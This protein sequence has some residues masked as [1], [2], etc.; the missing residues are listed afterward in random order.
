MS[1]E[2]LLALLVGFKYL[3]LYILVIVEGFFT[4]VAGGALAA[5]GIMN[6]FAVMAIVVLGD[7]TSDFLYFNF[8]KKISKTRFAKFLGLAPTQI[9]RVERIFTKHGP[10]TIIVAKLSSYLA[11]PV[12]VSA[13]AI[14]M[15]KKT[16]WSYC[17]FAATLKATVFVLLGYYFGTQIH[18]IVHAAII[19]SIIISITVTGY[20][21]GSHYLSTKSQ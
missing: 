5:Q 9:H 21:I 8:G 7:I 3:A 11:V 4:T 15:P 6:L 17:A 10:N 20:V 19:V 16:F 13:G 1:S 2:A 12:I 14:H 18:H